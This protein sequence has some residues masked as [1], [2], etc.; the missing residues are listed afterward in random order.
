ML[1]ITVF[2]KFVVIFGVALVIDAQQ[3]TVRPCQNP[4]F[5]QIFKACNE[6][7]GKNPAASVK[8]FYHGSKKLDKPCSDLLLKCES[9]QP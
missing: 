9:K 3:K 4:E 8:S 6:H 7:D 5:E 2:W 1:V